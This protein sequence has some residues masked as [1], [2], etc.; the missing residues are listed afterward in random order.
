MRL[1]TECQRA[2]ATNFYLET[3]GLVE[4]SSKPFPESQH[5]QIF[6]SRNSAAAKLSLAAGDM[7]FTPSAFDYSRLQ[8]N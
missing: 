3:P 5:F 7:G 1:S 8:F 2:K 6:I 4:G